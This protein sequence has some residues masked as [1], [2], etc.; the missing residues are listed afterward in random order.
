MTTVTIAATVAAVSATDGKLMMAASLRPQ[1]PNPQSQATTTMSMSMAMSQA[2]SSQSPTSST[3]SVTT[4]PTSPHFAQITRAHTTSVGRNAINGNGNSTTNING[5][6]N[7]NG[8]GG[9]GVYGHPYAQPGSAQ[10]NQHPHHRPGSS[11]SVINHPKPPSPP[12]YHPPPRQTFSAYLRTWS[13]NEITQFLNVYSCGHHAPAFQRNDI[14]GKCLLDLDQNTLKEMGVTRVGERLKIYNGIKELRKRV[15]ASMGSSSRTGSGSGPTMGMG[16]GMGMGMSRVE[17][18]LNGAATPPLDDVPTSSPG[19][20]ELYTRSNHPASSLRRLGSARPPPLDLHSQQPRNIIPHGHVHH[21]GAV[22]SSDVKTITPRPPMSKDASSSSLPTRNGSG[23]A[24]SIA[25]NTG[26][27]LLPGSHSLPASQ[28]GGS[29]NSSITVGSSSVPAPAPARPTN[30]SLRAPPIRDPG[31][32]SPSPVN[33]NAD[34]TGFVDRPLP[35]QPGINSS[36]SSAAE[37]ASAVR[38]HAEGRA[39]PTWSNEPSSYGS[40]SQR[41]TA[42]SSER[43]N[44]PP[45]TI[46]RND[47]A[48]RK[49]PSLGSA[50]STKQPSPVKH[51]FGTGSANGRA[52]TS[53]G[54]VHPFAANRAIREDERRAGTSP[55]DLHVPGGL[56][57]SSSGSSGM[58]GKNYRNA[59]YVVGTGGNMVS[60]SASITTTPTHAS[61]TISRRA[62]APAS[63]TLSLEDLRK[64]LVKFINSEDGTTRTVN[65]SSCTSGVEVLERVLKKFGKWGTGATVSTDT[66]SDEDGDRLEVDGWGVYEETEPDDDCESEPIWSVKR[67]IHADPIRQTFV[68]G[69]A[70]EYLCAAPRRYGR[71][72]EWSHTPTDS[73]TTLPQEHGS[74]PW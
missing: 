66:E 11:A 9:G 29:H 38:Y 56:N 50:P 21:G 65:V 49:N 60:R 67:S 7:G 47:L 42:P 39:T 44:Q 35:P 61:S 18:R 6:G 14:D 62:D 45:P 68:R 1:Q 10:S 53:N 27:S 46:V 23:S 17:L 22:S 19:L 74:F 71:A 26:G 3:S 28:T 40:S 70:S 69:S 20:D 55:P 63:G 57:S 52:N 5:N 34:A 37:Y 36:Q 24:S 8:G 51:K 41:P 16:M 32:R 48:H 72:R 64:Q 33:A 43:R 25:T 13:D 73:K 31:R 30:L 54:P 15:A 58:P 59:N 2:A 12:L 4:T